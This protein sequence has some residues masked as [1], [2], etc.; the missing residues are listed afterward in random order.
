MRKFT[1]YAGQKANPIAALVGCHKH[2]DGL[3]A[4]CNCNP[5]YKAGVQE[6]DPGDGRGPMNT[7]YHDGFTSLAAA[8]KWLAAEVKRLV[9][10]G[11]YIPA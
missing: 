4:T 9:A 10:T 2:G 1:T 8:E 3:W 6:V 7:S 11:Y 5:E